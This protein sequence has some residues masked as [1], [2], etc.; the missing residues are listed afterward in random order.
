MFKSLPMAGLLWGLSALFASPLP[1]CR[2]PLAPVIESRLGTPDLAPAHWGVVIQDLAS[3]ETLYQRNGDQ[4]FTPA[5]SLKLLVASAA[6]RRLGADFRWQTPVYLRGAP[7]LL[8]E[9]ILDAQGDPTLTTAQLGDLAQTL[10]QRG[11]TA[12]GTLTLTDAAPPQ[13]R[14][15]ESWEWGDLAYGYAPAVNQAILNGNQGTLTLTPETL[16]QPLKLEVSDPLALGTVSL[17]NQ[18]RVAPEP[19]PLELT[20]VWGTSQ[21]ILTGSLP[22]EAEP[23]RLTFA[24]PDPGAYFLAALARELNR[25]GIRVGE[26][27]LV[28]DFSPPSRPG[29][30]LTSPPLR[31]IVA[32]INQDSDNLYAEALGRLLQRRALPLGPGAADLGLKDYSGLSRQ[33]LLSP[34]FLTNLL[35]EMAQTPAASVFRDSLALMGERGTLRRRLLNTPVAGKFWGKTGALTG[36]VS[37]AGYWEIQPRRTLAVAILVNNSRLGAGDLRRAID[38]LLLE[39]LDQCQ[40]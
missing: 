7:P 39:I 9:L 32:R 25:R 34:R 18:T 11:V 29:F 15:P 28:Q 10:R 16:G 27:R 4:L 23:A 20:G 31:D 3:G 6:L 12:I 22:P 33:N 37:L 40:G 30:T 19:R 17:S 26:E 1:A 13:R 8:E 21:W 14:H 5:S 35:R 36:T 2:R 24:V 38:E